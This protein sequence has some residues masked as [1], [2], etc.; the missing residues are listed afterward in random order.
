MEKNQRF[1]QKI[2]VYGQSIQLLGTLLFCL[3][4]AQ[5]GGWQINGIWAAVEEQFAGKQFESL[6]QCLDTV[7]QFRNQH[8]A[9]VEQP[10][11]NEREAWRAMRTW[12]SCVNRMVNLSR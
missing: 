4:Y 3:D 1:L 8:V 12:L 6:H 9:H 11:T 5:Q 10:I 7:N 2:L